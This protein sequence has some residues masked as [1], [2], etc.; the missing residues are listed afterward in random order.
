MK[1]NLF[2]YF[3]QA[4]L[5]LLS[6]LC[7]LTC[8]NSVVSD[9]CLSLHKSNSPHVQHNKLVYYNFWRQ[10]VD[11]YIHKM[12]NGVRRVVQN[13][14]LKKNI[15][16]DWIICGVNEETT[17]TTVTIPEHLH[18]NQQSGQMERLLHCSHQQPPTMPA[19]ISHCYL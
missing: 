9:R 19:I 15:F 5:E 17:T 16:V 11:K 3:Q 2:L 4:T 14:K 8:F 12:N 13:G 1:W 7:H 10:Y 6:S 18:Q